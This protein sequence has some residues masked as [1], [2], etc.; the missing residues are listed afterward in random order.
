MGRG[1][2]NFYR[3]QNDNHQQLKEVEEQDGKKVAEFQQLWLEF[4]S[5]TA[6][7]H[8]MFTMLGLLLFLL[9]GDPTLPSEAGCSLFVLFCMYH[10]KM[11]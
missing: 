2:Y 3:L 6:L 1:G 11:L 4:N 7:K 8:D 5:G 9:P 10:Y